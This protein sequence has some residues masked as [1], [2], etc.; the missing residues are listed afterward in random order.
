[1]LKGDRSLE[2]EQ[3]PP[4]PQLKSRPNS[5]NWYAPT[6]Q[7]YVAP[8]PQQHT[9]PTPPQQQPHHQPLNDISPSDSTESV[10]NKTLQSEDIYSDIDTIIV[11]ASSDNIDTDFEPDSVDNNHKVFNNLLSKSG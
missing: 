7:Q 5:P 4:P 1:M 10:E 6:P 2:V 3:Y 8:T 11:N 9:A